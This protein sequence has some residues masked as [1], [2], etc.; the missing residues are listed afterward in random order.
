MHKLNIIIGT[1]F[2]A[3]LIP[4]GNANS[5]ELQPY[6]CFETAPIQRILTALTA[7]GYKVDHI[8]GAGAANAQIETHLLESQNIGQFQSEDD[9]A[10][11]IYRQTMRVAF[12]TKDA[13]HYE[14]LV[15]GETA[16]EVCIEGAI[17]ILLLQPEYKLISIYHGGILASEYNTL[18][19]T[20]HQHKK[21]DH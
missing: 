15:T 9:P 18:N 8:S 21:F 13:T 11:T 6:Y 5:E 10:I 2:F 16:R 20:N 14:V 19:P 7:S 4:I 1:V 12:N 3:I 17:A